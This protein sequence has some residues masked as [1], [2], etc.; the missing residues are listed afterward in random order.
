MSRICRPGILLAAFGLCLCLASDGVAQTTKPKEKEK[1]NKPERTTPEDST[2]PL[3]NAR[4]PYEAIFFAASTPARR[5]SS[6]A[7]NASVVEVYDQDEVDEGEPQLDGLYTSFTGDLDFRR[8]DSRTTW[9]ANGGA[10]LR[11]YQQLDQF[12]AA[13]YRGSAG[14]ETG[15]ASRTT[16]FLNE[17]LSLSPVSLPNLFATPLPPEVG[18][19]VPPGNSNFALTD[20]KYVTSATAASIEHR[21]SVRSQLVV[22]G[23]YRY[24][25]YL[26]DVSPNSDWSILDSGVVY[27]FRVAEAR[28]LRAGY[29]YRWASEAWN[30]P[31]AG[32][33]EAKAGEHSFF[34]GA[35]LNRE[36][37]DRQ[38][39]MLS[40]DAGT[41]VFSAQSSTDLLPAGY[42]RQFVL[43]AALA[44]QIGETWLLVAA[45][46]R[47]S[48]FDQG[49]GAPVFANAVSLSATGFLSPRADFSAWVSYTAGEPV[50]SG[51]AQGFTTGTA[52]G[53]VRFAVARRVA[54]TAEIFRYRYDFTDS[55]NFPFLTGVPLRFA[56]NSIRGGVVITLPIVG[57]R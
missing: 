23:N 25:H 7:F 56:R 47:G 24:S 50:L 30:T 8:S 52:G 44:H 26:G 41:S 12:L 9:A 20:D 40:I 29:S 4:P 5:G 3:G 35:A 49:N 48:Q 43:D 33:R 37:S 55:P 13:D 22:R 15:V 11:Y 36:F 10:N 19:P 14:V 45:F 17:A 31:R 1:G 32:G 39:T 57:G 16:L 27:R 53:R 34:V 51:T 42:E 46:D 21:F 28:S 54:L 18:D 2:E 6:L 38:R